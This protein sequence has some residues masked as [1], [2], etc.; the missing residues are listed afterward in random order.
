MMKDAMLK[1]QMDVPSLKMDAS[2]T[3]GLKKD[4]G[5]LM[6]LETV[7][8]VPKTLCQQKASLRY[9]EPHPSFSLNAK[10]RFHGCL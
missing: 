7:V 10:D 5:L 9:G 8:K 3:A 2:F 1:L 6:D 4:E